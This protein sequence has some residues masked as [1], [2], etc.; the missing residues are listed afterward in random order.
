MNWI[1]VDKPEKNESGRSRSCRFRVTPSFTK[2]LH[3]ESSQIVGT[4]VL[5]VATRTDD[6]FQPQTEQQMVLLINAKSENQN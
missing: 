1:S 6:H 5:P 3:N 2:V 4:A